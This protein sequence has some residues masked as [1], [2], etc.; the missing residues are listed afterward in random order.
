MRK[1]IEEFDVAVIPNTDLQVFTLDNLKVLTDK[2][3]RMSWL[4]SEK[5]DSKWIAEK[6]ELI[7]SGA[8]DYSIDRDYVVR[9]ETDEDGEVK[10]IVTYFPLEKKVRG[11][12][13]NNSKKELRKEHDDMIMRV[14]GEH[15]RDGKAQKGEC[16]NDEG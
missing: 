13:K 8:Y 15:W 14:L 1:F 3:R 11:G 9:T 4:G 12:D 16:L 10:E 6:T 2:F 7:V 5:H